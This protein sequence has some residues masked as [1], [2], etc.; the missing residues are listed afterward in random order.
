MS[1]GSEISLEALTA[2]QLES[3]QEL[4]TMGV[5]SL[6]TNVERT[7]YRNSLYEC[8]DL[9]EETLFVQYNA[10]MN[11]EGYSVA[12][13]TKDVLGFIDN[14][15]FTR[16]IIDVR[17]NGG[18]NSMLFDPFINQ[19]G[20]RISAGQCKG[21]VLIGT[22]T[23]SSAVLNA[24]DLKKAGCT[25][26]GTPTGGAINHYGEFGYITLPHSGINAT[27]STKHFILD[28]K[29]VPGSIQPDVLVELSVDDLRSGYDA[30][31]AACLEM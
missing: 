16:V 29:A 22:N 18:G 12:D 23:F 24:W 27:Y 7:L 21:F 15:G 5:C 28:P 14:I 31:T 10:C 11:A 30:Q 8:Y 6:V 4:T 17:N 20:K 2:E 13:F 9:D 19:L 26:V 25:L 1:D 3:E